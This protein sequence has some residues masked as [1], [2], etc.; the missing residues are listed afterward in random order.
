MLTGRI[1]PDSGEIGVGQTVKIAHYTQE[2]TEMNEQLRVIDYIKEV[3]EV[4]QTVDGHKITA[5]QMLERF[6]F[7]PH[8]QWTPIAKLSG[9]ERRRLYLLRTLMSEPNVL[10]LDEPTNDLDIQTLAILEDYLEHFLGA[11]I[12]VS[13]DRYFLDRT[14]DHLLVF[15][16]KG[17]IRRFTGNYTDYLEQNKMA[18]ETST[19]PITE[20]PKKEITTKADAKLPLKLSYNEQK[21]WDEI[22]N[23]IADLEEQSNQLK[24][25]ISLAASDFEKV[26]RLY[27]KEQHVSSELEETMERWTV[28]SLLLEEIENNKL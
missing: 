26:Q 15:E 21:E 17:K 7:P 3:A 20:K 27:E 4:I 1:Q 8:I 2:N 5:A 6:L 13:H 25:E 12:I 24:K 28:L 14:A 9:G 11:V 16:G 22:E 23:R 19:P 18:N 10:L